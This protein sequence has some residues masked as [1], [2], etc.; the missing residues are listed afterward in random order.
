MPWPGERDRAAERAARLPPAPPREFRAAWV[1]TVA[2][3][4]WPSKPGLSSAEQISEIHAILD[5]AEK[6]NL[7]A[8]VLQVRTTCDALYASPLEPWSEYLS[9]KQGVPPEPYYDPLA[10]WVRE[11]HQR[12]IELHAWF[13]P[14][15]ARHS[16]AKSPDAPTHV[17]NTKPHIVRKFHKWEWLDPGEPEARKQ[18]LDVIADVVRR[19]DIDGV[20]LDDYFYPYPDYYKDPQTKQATLTDF[21]DDPSWQRYQQAGGAL[22][23][24]DWRR[25]NVNRMIQDIHTLIKANKPHVKFGI[26]PFGIA[27]PGMPETVKSGFDQYKTLYA[28]AQLWLNKG[29]CDYWTP[30]LYW[31]IDGP[32]PYVDLLTWWAGQNPWGRHLWPGNYISGLGG[33]PKAWGAQEIVDQIN[34]TREVVGPYSGNVHFSMIAMMQNR[35]QLNDALLAG[36]YAQAAL[37]PAS[38]W[39]DNKPLAAPQVQAGVARDGSVQVSWELLDMEEA[40]RWAVWVK[41]GDEWRFAV[42]PAHV[43]SVRIEPDPANP[44]EITAVTVASVDRT[45]N[46]NFAEPLSLVGRKRR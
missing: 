45:G 6:L 18:T 44:R 17:A 37:V 22:S 34:A 2:N 40:S 29:W 27:R 5:Q 10:T 14:Y 8:I 3:I 24:E 35:A 26:S 16:G 25:E 9:G 12:G 7:N 46:A 41:Y 33:G 32:Q 19:Y 11:A 31:K 36:P 13:N 43:R 30:Q 21:P 28:D 20:H 15:R 23:R 39:L 4:D 42:Y 1:A 38:P